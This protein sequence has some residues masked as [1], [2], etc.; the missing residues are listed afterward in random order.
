M[1]HFVRGLG[2]IGEAVMNLAFWP[3]ENNLTAAAASQSSPLL[4]PTARTYCASIRE[5][6]GYW[7][8]FVGSHLSKGW[9]RQAQPPTKP[10]KPKPD[11]KIKHDSAF[12]IIC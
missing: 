4:R 12:I 9:T 3:G 1:G 2:T 11:I 7:W 6:Y 10:K 8:T 5:S